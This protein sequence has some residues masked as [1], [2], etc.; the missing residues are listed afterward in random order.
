VTDDTDPRASRY[1]RKTL[2]ISAALLALWLVVTLAVGLFGQS[3]AFVVFGWPFGFWVTAQGALI[4]FCLIV[5]A[6]AWAMDRLD[7]Q[8]GDHAED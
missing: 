4:V 6:Y 1:W 7:R 2:R 3:L 5:W 8:Y